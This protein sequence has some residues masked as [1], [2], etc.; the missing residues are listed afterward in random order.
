MQDYGLTENDVEL[1][2][3]GDNDQIL[4]AFER[5]EIDAA[6]STDLVYAQELYFDSGIAKLLT[7]FSTYPSHSYVE[8]QK[9]FI[10]EHPE[11]VKA[12]LQALYKAEKWYAENLDEGDQITADFCDADIK[13][14]TKGRTNETVG[15][16]FDEDDITNITQ[17]YTYLINNELIENELVVDEIINTDILNDAIAAVND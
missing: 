16:A 2:N 5:N 14:V 10:D 15:L 7:D 17:T 13:D 6:I 4:A 12:F 3:L 8:F 11:T 9:S 1:V